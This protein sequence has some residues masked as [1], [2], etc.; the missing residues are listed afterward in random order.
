MNPSPTKTRKAVAS[1]AVAIAN[2]HAESWRIAYRGMLSD[3][4]LDK[5]VFDERI[6]V[7]QERFRV[8]AANQYILVAEVDG[9]MIGFACAYG[10]EDQKWGSFLDNL[11]VADAFK[12]RGIGA[13]L[14]RQVAQWSS[15]QYPGAGMYLWVLESNTPAMRFYEKL[16]GV[17]SGEGVW[18]PSDGGNYRKYRYAWTSL[19]PLRA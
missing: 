12:R 6:A 15:G 17:R 13:G 7:W 2:L 14:M 8:P 5:H 1:D 4:F 11:H 16:G 10:G 18:T 3:E 9:D 19:D